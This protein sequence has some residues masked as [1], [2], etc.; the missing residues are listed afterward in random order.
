MRLASPVSRLAVLLALAPLA[1]PAQEA[2]APLPR[3]V[4]VTGEGQSAAKPDLAR[5]GLGVGHQAPT[6]AEAMALMADGMEAVL[7]RLA[8]E[9]IAS[10]DIRTGQLV[11][12]PAWNYNTPDGNPLMTGFTATQILEVTVRDLARV[13]A[14]LDAVVQDGANRVN[15]VSFDL[16]DPQAAL[17]EARRDAVADARARAEI[18]A[19]AAGVALGDLVTIADATGYPPVPMYDA[20]GGA[21]MEAAVPVAPGQMTLSASV[22]MTWAI[23][24][25]P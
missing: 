14:V 16:A 18:Y 7:A 11:L 10:A 3:T 24:G 15:G 2:P 23:A 19:D 5:I 17:D 20:R 22:A 25:T 21:A 9:G 12:E 4:T 13:G 1:L 6:A 8:Q